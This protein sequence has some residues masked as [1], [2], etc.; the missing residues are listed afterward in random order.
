MLVADA[1]SELEPQNILM[2]P[3]QMVELREIEDAAESEAQ[4]QAL[5][6]RMCDAV[7]E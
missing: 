6:N 4:A 1:L 7:G 2:P 3:R 5:Y